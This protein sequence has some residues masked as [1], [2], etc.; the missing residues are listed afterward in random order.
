MELE[1]VLGLTAGVAGGLFSAM[2]ALVAWITQRFVKQN[3]KI[4]EIQ[5]QHAITMAAVVVKVEHH[6]DEI[7]EINSTL[8]QLPNVK[9]RRNT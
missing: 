1:L 6:D 3:D 8:K 4:V 5:T 9:Y 2:M 7:S